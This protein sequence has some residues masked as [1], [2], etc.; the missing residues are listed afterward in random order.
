ME[1]HLRAREQTWVQYG[2]LL[3]RTRKPQ[4]TLKKLQVKHDINVL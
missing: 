2:W 4:G 3:A 1:I